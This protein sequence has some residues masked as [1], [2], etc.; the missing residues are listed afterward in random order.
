MAEN[1]RPYRLFRNAAAVDANVTRESMSG[2]KSGLIELDATATRH[3]EQRPLFSYRTA[4]SKVTCLQACGSNS[5]PAVRLSGPYHSRSSAA[6]ADRLFLRSNSAC[7]RVEL[8]ARIRQA[9]KISAMDGGRG[10]P[11][12]AARLASVERRRYR[13]SPSCLWTLW[14]A[15]YLPPAR[16]GSPASRSCLEECGLRS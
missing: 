12:V 16:R 9:K 15:L 6:T 7:R 5:T 3:L 1:T 14:S 8:D 2:L 13:R 11:A 4:A 10:A